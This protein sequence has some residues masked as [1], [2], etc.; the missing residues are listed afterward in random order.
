VRHVHARLDTARL[1]AAAGR[2]SGLT[3]LAGGAGR[4]L[5]GASALASLISPAGRAALARSIERATAD[6]YAGTSDHVLRA[7]T[8]H[9][10]IAADGAS[11]AA[12]GGL[13]SATIEVRIRIAALNRPQRIAA[14][15]GARPLSDLA[16]E[17]A[18][19][20]SGSAG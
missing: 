20:G 11:S 13:R 3:G 14:P 16:A 17:L 4:A 19:P 6:L 12:L 2:L 8:A 9:V 18:Q 10:Q 7:L 15:S 5:P 1:L